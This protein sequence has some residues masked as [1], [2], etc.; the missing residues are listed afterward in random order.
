M[1]DPS[2]VA[3]GRRRRPPV[4]DRERRCAPWRT[5]GPRARRSSS[6]PLWCADGREVRGA[7]VHG[8]QPAKRWLVGA[9]R[10]AGC[11]VSANG[12]DGS[13]AVTPRHAA[14]AHAGPRPCGVAWA[15]DASA[16]GVRQVRAGTLEGV[17][18]GQLSSPCDFPLGYAREKAGWGILSITFVHRRRP[19]GRGSAR[20][21][22]PRRVQRS[23]NGRNR[24]V[25]R[26]PDRRRRAS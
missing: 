26:P 13:R 4:G 19:D 18:G 3:L 21:R 5:G 8:G 1:S 14:V 9:G 2:A 23:R 20:S 12:A 25:Q 6:S 22:T 7:R 10:G 24:S 16:T 15:S 17:D 11:G